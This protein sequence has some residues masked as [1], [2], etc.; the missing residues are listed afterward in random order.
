MKFIG[1]LNIH[2]FVGVFYVKNN[3][4]VTRFMKMFV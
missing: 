3:R 2:I 1:Q 4:H